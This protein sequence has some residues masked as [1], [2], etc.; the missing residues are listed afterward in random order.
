MPNKPL[1]LWYSSD[2]HLFEIDNAAK[3]GHEHDQRIAGHK[4]VHHDALEDL[5]AREDLCIPE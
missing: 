1:F 4:V 5:Q 3:A 2:S